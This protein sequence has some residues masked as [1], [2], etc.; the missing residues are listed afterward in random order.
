MRSLLV[1]ATFFT[2]AYSMAAA[3][4]VITFRHATFDFDAPSPPLTAGQQA[5]FQRYKNAVNQHDEAAFMALQDGSMNS[6]AFVSRKLILQHFDKTIPD[7]VKVRFF[8]ATEDIAKEMG[9]GDLAYP[10]AQPTAVLGITGRTTSER[11]IKI[12][13][14][15]APVRQTGESFAFVPHCL[16][17]KGKALLE[18]KRG[19]Q[20]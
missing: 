16:T 14:I 19:T 8:D 11:E 9:F 18:Q 1:A 3:T 12:V 10:S 13:T 2:A 7:S 4:D 6:C 20:P 5:F 15:L 17:E